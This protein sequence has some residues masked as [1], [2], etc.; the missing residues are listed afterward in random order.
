MKLFVIALLFSFPNSMQAIEGRNEKFCLKNSCFI[1]VIETSS[2]AVVKERYSDFVKSV[3]VNPLDVAYFS[4]E[5]AERTED[6]KKSIRNHFG[7]VSNADLYYV[8]VGEDYSAVLLYSPIHGRYV[9]YFSHHLNKFEFS[10]DTPPQYEAVDK[11]W[12][13]SDVIPAIT[14]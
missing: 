10:F 1:K 5:L 4:E 2:E 9:L 7:W 8:L 13:N 11:L 3:R 6:P 14:R 12:V